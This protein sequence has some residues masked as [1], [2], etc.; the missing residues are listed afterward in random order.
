MVR[1]WGLDMVDAPLYISL[2]V[3]EHYHL[4]SDRPRVVCTKQM[5][6]HAYHERKHHFAASSSSNFDGNG[7]A[8]P[9]MVEFD[10]RLSRTKAAMEF[11]WSNSGQGDEAAHA[12]LLGPSQAAV[13]M[14]NAL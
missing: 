1:R 8:G 14:S 9:R 6:A 11:Q 2:V 7:T 12:T 10:V 5:S 4:T 13:T 3:V